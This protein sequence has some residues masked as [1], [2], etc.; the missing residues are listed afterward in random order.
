MVLHGAIPDEAAGIS[1]LIKGVNYGEGVGVPSL[2]RE[3]ASIGD[4]HHSIGTLKLIGIEV[5]EIIE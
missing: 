5:I 1:V 2:L 4:V 3:A